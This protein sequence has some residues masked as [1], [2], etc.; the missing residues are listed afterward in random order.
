MG[1]STIYLSKDVRKTDGFRNPISLRRSYSSSK[2]N[3]DHRFMINHI[4]HQAMQWNTKGEIR[5]KAIH[6]KHASLS[7]RSFFVLSF[8]SNYIT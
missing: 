2:D 5:Y 7:G 3:I 6:N 8:N 1:Q 4:V